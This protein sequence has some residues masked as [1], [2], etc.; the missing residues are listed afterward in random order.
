MNNQKSRNI[1]WGI[2]EN[3]FQFFLLVLVN[4]FVGGMVG[5]ERS[6]FPEYAKQVMG[7][8]SA[9]IMLSFIVAFGFSKAVANYYAGRWANRWGRRQ[10]LIAGWCLALPVPILLMMAHSWWIVIFANILLGVH[11]GLTWSSTVVMKMDLVGKKNR[12]LAMGI[13]EFAGYLAVGVVAYWTFQVAKD[14]GVTP[15]PFFIG[16]GIAV[17]GLL[18][19]F[20]WVKDTTPWMEKEANAETSVKARHFFIW[21]SFKDRNLSSIVQAGWVNNLNDGMMWGLLPMLLL[22]RGVDSDTSAMALATYPMVWGFGQL[23]TGKWSDVISKKGLIAS[24]MALQGAVILVM[25]IAELDSYAVVLAALLGWGTAMV[26]PTFLSAI[27]DAVPARQRAETV[28]IF[29][30]WRDSGY[31]FG[32]IIS[33]IL[34]DLWGIP[35]AMIFIGGLTMLSG[36]VVQLRMKS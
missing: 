34:A 33:G 4:G 12:G 13:N 7:I 35:V 16:L 27:G 2:R 3:A 15:Y 24:G 5:M 8:S 19:S 18:L 1:R 29:R 9:G 11:Q 20:L 14:F 31:A 10:L 32:A 23:I 21:V 17:V 30:L 26:Y 6:I 28:G 36:W 25:A 22:E